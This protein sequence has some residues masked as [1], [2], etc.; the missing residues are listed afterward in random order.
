MTAA[1]FSARGSTSG[2]PPPA[3]SRRVI[4]AA[5][6]ARRRLAHDLHDGAQQQLTAALV[7]LGRVQDKWSEDPS[8][9]RRLLDEAVQEIEAG[10][11]ALRDLAAGVHPSILTHRGLLAALDALGASAPLPVTLDLEGGRLPAPVEASVYFFVAE[12]LTNVV[13]HAHASKAWV[14]LAITRH[15][16]TIAVGDDGIGG[17]ERTLGGTGLWS[18]S[19]RVAALDGRLRITSPP[20]VG[21]TVEAAMGL[22]APVVGGRE[23]PLAGGGGRPI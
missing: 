17:A 3:D 18:L 12:A 6:A 21:T 23:R 7:D 14:R 19:D 20:G 9:T 10:I 4:E 22:P 16:L 13:K 5:D 1:A 15:E 2:A 11:E 8:Q